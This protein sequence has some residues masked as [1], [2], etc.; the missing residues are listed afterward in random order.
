MVAYII[1]TRV[2]TTNQA[3]L[4]TYSAA[5]PSTIAGHETKILSAYNK[6]EVFV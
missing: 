4:D 5:A 3:E 1:F 2:K 6:F